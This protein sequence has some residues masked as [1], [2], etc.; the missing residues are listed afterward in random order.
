[1]PYAEVCHPCGVFPDTNILQY[2]VSKRAA[3]HAPFY[4]ILEE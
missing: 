1:M 4:I 2:I 3:K